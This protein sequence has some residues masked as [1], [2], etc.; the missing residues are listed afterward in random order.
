MRFEMTRRLTRALQASLLLLL[1]V[2]QGCSQDDGPGAE[3]WRV[4]VGEVDARGGGATSEDI[5]EVDAAR[6]DV[7]DVNDIGEPPPPTATEDGLEGTTWY[8]V[9]R[10]A[11]NEGI[12]GNVFRVE[13]GANGAA[14][15]D[16]YGQLTGEWEIFE[17]R[18]LRLFN[19]ERDGQPNEP[20]QLVF[21]LDEDDEGRAR[22]FDLFIGQGPG[23]VPYNLRLEQLDADPAAVSR[24]AGDWQSASTFTDE[25]GSNLRLAVRFFGDRVG[26]G[27]YNG[28]YIEFAVATS[29]VMTMDTGEVYWLMIPPEAGAPAVFAGELAIDEGGETTL[30]APRQT[31]PGQQPAVFTSEPL[32]SVPSFSL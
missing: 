9:L 11:V 30:Y 18:R 8:G 32:V 28:A 14:V 7:V 19:L 16:L 12:T 4:D 24:L 10:L 20:S 22:G 17:S 31:N 3:E 23:D 15:V 25:N 2:P 6:M 27:L 1:W 5:A 29:A 26:Y 21:D 13:L